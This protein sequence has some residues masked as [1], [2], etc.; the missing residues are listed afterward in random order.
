[1]VNMKKFKFDRLKAPFLILVLIFSIV[2]FT[3]TASSFAL[4]QLG[5]ETTSTVNETETIEQTGTVESPNTSQTIDA[6]DSIEPTTITD[7]TS[8]QFDSAWPAFQGSWA[9]TGLSQADPIGKP[10]ILWK[11]E[12]GIQSWLNNPIIVG[13]LV[14]VGSSGETW[15][16]RDDQD[17][18]Y[19]LDLDTGR[20]A[21]FMKAD[22][23]VNGVAYANGLVFATD[24]GS[25]VRALNPMSGETIWRTRT[26]GMAVY[27][28]PL[29]VKDIVVVGDFTGNLSAF[30][31][32][33]GSLRWSK[34]LNG[35]IRGG[36]SS[37]G[38]TIYVCSASGMVL[39]IN[40]DGTENWSLQLT[41]PSF[42]G[43]TEEPAEIYAAPT[44][45][46][47]L[48]IVG[49]ARDTAYD[50]PA[51]VGIDRHNGSIKWRASNP[52]DLE[53]GWGNIR[54]SP[55]IYEDLFIYGEPYSNRIVAININNGRVEWSAETG[56]VMFPHWPSP[57]IVKDIV[58]APRH[59]GGLYALHA[60]SGE[61]FWSLY[62]GDAARSGPDFPSDLVD[63]EW[64]EGAWEPNVGKSIFASPAIT[65]D[66]RIVIG[67]DQGYIFCIGEK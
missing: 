12:I 5:I 23:D 21:W 14:I 46:D 1:M 43:D 17:G 11:T 54:S 55:A 20:I 22:A 42:E 53:G 7:S 67:T 59:N 57:A 58:I 25:Y 15:N 4:N 63:P 19:A 56:G 60:D 35:A 24:D 10:N 28:N 64:P 31:Q 61:L 39:A 18:V 13:N 30:S 47:D 45:V 33:D 26:N 51:F 2:I 50:I 44:I 49:F 41:R 65:N 48:L 16:K 40:V 36:A 3:K 38:E 62:L 52:H 8:T 32:K 6:T 9:R 27:T 66:G 29:A 37:D 34:K